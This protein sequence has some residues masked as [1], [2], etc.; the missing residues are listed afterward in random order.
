VITFPHLETSSI[1][2]TS[3]MNGGSPSAQLVAHPSV[4][5]LQELSRMVELGTLL[6]GE[7]AA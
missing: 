6:A 2:A 3:W 1:G 4:A 5:D 7:G